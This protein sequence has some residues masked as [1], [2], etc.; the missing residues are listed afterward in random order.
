MVEI[1]VSGKKAEELAALHYPFLD[2]CKVEGKTVILII[3]EAIDIKE[4]KRQ[5]HI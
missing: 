4:A 2:I 5:E 3:G 1:F